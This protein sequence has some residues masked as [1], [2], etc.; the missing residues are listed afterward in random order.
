MVAGA[1]C[2]INHLYLGIVDHILDIQVSAAAKGLLKFLYSLGDQVA[3]GNHLILIGALRKASLVDAH[4]NS[5]QTYNT[6]FNQLRH[7][8]I[9]FIAG[10][11]RHPLFL[12]SLYQTPPSLST[13][14][15][16]FLFF[17]PPPQQG[18]QKWKVQHEKRI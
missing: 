7:R 2:D 8:F 16:I 10:C 5:T 18:A 11:A 3:R 12:S 9:S 1:G 6:N 13:A 15:C 14:Q 17:L 4:T